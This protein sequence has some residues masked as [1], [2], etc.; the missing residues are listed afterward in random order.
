MPI[1]GF[2]INEFMGYFSGSRH[3]YGEHIYTD[4]VGEDGKRQGKSYTITDKLLTIEEYKQH[5]KGQKGIGVVPINEQSKCRFAVIDI[6]IYDMDL[7]MYLEAIERN[8]FPI[9]PFKSKSGGL[10]LYVFFKEEV[11]ATSAIDIMRKFA[12]YLSI[13]KLV[14]NKKNTT[15]EVY[16]KQ[17]KLAKGDVG[18]WI[19]LPYFN[20]EKTTSF[21]VKGGNS[22]TLTDALI[23]IKEKETTLID[24][25]NFLSNLE[26]SDAP[27]C[28]QLIYILN[29]LR[30][31]SGRNNYLF[32]FGVYLKKKDEEF[33]EQNLKGIN[34]GLKNPI[35]QKEVDVT[36]TAS[37]KRKEYLYKCSDSPCVDFCNKKECRMREFGIGKNEGYFSSV[38]CGQLYQFR[39]AQP[40]Y[41]WEVK[42]QGQEVFK[43]L[44]FKSEEEVIKQDTF[45]KLCM[46]ELH[47]L[48]SKLKQTEWFNKVNQAL[49][50]IKIIDVHKDDDTS[51]MI[52]LRNLIIDFLTGRA[53][54]ESK[55]Q[56]VVKRVFYSKPDKEYW[57]RLKDLNEYLYVTKQL[58][59]F[60][61]Q[62]LHGILREMHCV[63][64]KIRTESGKQIRICAFSDTQLEA[65]FEEE[66]FTPNFDQYKEEF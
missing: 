35:D 14:K 36:I 52:I 3:N 4:A 32:S 38:E 10:H 57:F 22:L 61:P 11:P 19:N 12:F 59:Y 64:K 58:K 6:D 7:S 27:P 49:K 55:D 62:E 50:E 34:E 40:Y 45:L 25:D 47:E 46:R 37:L 39:T 41:E 53:K 21:A 60:G 42:L 18:S 17:S 56:I 8:K 54:A 33:F 63:T 65:T 51:P 2:Q 31:G 5:L 30:E 1:S 66:V 29:P 24:V 20:A 15:V 26:Y 43:S 44:R 48:P 16:P 28:L 13:D 9:V 23:F